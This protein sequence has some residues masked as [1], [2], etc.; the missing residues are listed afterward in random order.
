M[1][2]FINLTVVWFISALLSGCAGSPPVFRP[3]TLPSTIPVRK[4]IR[5]THEAT[6]KVRIDIEA[7]QAEAVAA[8]HAKS[9]EEYKARTTRILDALFGAHNDAVE[10]EAK[11]A[12]AETKVDTLEA[13]LVTAQA[14]TAETE[15]RL[16]YLEPKYNAAVGIIWKW[17]VYAIGTWAV[18]GLLIAGKI[19]FKSWLPFL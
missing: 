5:V 13:E 8:A 7:A 17:R 16:N 10:A 15:K 6:T 11:A 3:V 9:T 4:A 14:Q 19:Y 18:I 1:K 2:Y 12:I